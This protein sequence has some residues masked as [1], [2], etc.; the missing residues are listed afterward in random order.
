MNR[1]WIVR[2]IGILI[3][4]VFALVMMNLQRKLVMIQQSRPAPTATTT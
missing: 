2:I 1:L 4:V 3:I